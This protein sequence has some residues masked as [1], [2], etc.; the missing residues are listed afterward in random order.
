MALL[1]D[2]G[3]RAK[4]SAGDFTAGE[5]D[6][7]ITLILKAYTDAGYSDLKWTHER[8]VSIHWI[9]SDDAA[10][11]QDVLNDFDDGT[12]Q[13]W[14]VDYKANQ[15]VGYPQIAVA[16][17]YVLSAPYSVKMT[18]RNY[19]SD[20]LS[21]SSLYKSFITPDRAVV[22]AI[23]NCRFTP[24]RAEGF[25]RNRVVYIQR[26]GTILI[27][28]GASAITTVDLFP[29]GKWMR[30][31]VPLPKNTALEV[32]VTYEWLDTGAPYNAYAWM[33]NF[34]IISK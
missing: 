2:F 9:K 31:V 13:G 15:S 24:E 8:T 34:K 19:S 14:A 22:F 1:F 6:E 18:Q 5:F 3:S 32:K 23:I 28:L 12:V 26:N 7:S 27:Q 29:R 21:R 17:D 20:N 11:T 25:S 10:W 4:P 30:M 16:T 33:D